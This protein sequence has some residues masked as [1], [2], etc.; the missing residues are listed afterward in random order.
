MRPLAVA[1]TF[2]SPPPAA[3][4]TSILSRLSCAF[5]SSACA[6]CAI[7]MISSKSGISG[8]SG[9]SRGKGFE[10]SFRERVHHGPDIGIGKYVRAN[11]LLR[12]FLLIEKRW[13]TGIVRQG[14]L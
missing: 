3:P 1:R 5:W 6:F 9:A 2:T 4:S 11:A 12:H 7:F 10:F 13:R 8:I 14:H